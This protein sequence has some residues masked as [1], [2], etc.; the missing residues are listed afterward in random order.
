M[1]KILF[2]KSEGYYRDR[3]AILTAGEIAQ[4]PAVWRKAADNMLSRKAEIKEFMDEVMSIK[5]LRIVFTGAGSSAFIGEAMMFMLANEMGIRTEAVHS[6]DIISAP[7]STLFDVPT[8][9]ISYGRSGESPESKAVIDF[10]AKRIKNLYN[11]VIVC[12]K[13]STLASMGRRMENSMVLDMPEESSDKGFAMTSSVSCMALA[14][15][16]LFHYKE[17]EKYAGYIKLIADSMSQQM[18]EIAAKAEEIARV[19]Y[20]RIFWLGTGALKGLAREAAI[21]SMELSDGYVNSGYDAPTGFRHGPKTVINN[22]TITVHFLSNQE[23]SLRYDVDLAEEVIHEKDKNV[24]VTVKPESKKDATSG[25]D[26]EVIY[27]IPAMLPANS[28]IGAYIGSLLFAQ[29]L[30]MMKS[31]EKGYMTDSPCKK[32]TVNRVVK[33]IVIYDI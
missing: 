13:N 14:T 8:L 7:D 26:Y 27:K 33:G 17:I 31:L 5:D 2:G 23:Y 29:L 11:I 10:A 20:R 9:L 3:G 30:S 21:K 1:E 18:D 22:E 16:C 15:W 32:G 19:D 28:E 25:E 24:V 6:T 12:D 4:Q